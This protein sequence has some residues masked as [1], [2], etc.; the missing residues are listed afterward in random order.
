MNFAR[1]ISGDSVGALGGGTGDAAEVEVVDIGDAPEGRTIC[2][3]L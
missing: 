2:G 1:R 3:K